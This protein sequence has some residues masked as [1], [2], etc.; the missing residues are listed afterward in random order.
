[1]TNLHNN[2]YLGVLFMLNSCPKLELLTFD[3][4]FGRVL[5]K[6]PN[7]YYSSEVEDED[8]YSD[9]NDVEEEEYSSYGGGEN[10]IG[11]R[12]Q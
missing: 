7:E 2:E 4:G 5:D 10:Q 9:V 6:A 12:D 1:M 11:G 3:L 8:E